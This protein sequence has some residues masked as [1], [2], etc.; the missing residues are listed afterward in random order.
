MR[1]SL[2]SS[3]L[4]RYLR[5]QLDHFFPDGRSTARLEQVVPRALERVE[6]C[7]AR[8]R[9]PAY[10]T[11]GAA[12]FNH[13]HCDQYASFLYLASNVAWSECGDVELASKLF[14]LNKALNGIVCMYDTIL[15]EA[16]ILIHTV[17]IVLGKATYGNYF[18]VC[19]NALVGSDRGLAPVLADGV[20]IFGGSSVIGD[21]RIGDHV[22]L[23]AGSTLLH[24]AVPPRSIVAGRSPELIIKPARR[25]LVQH[26]FRLDEPG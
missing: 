6:H 21:C 11:E 25:D 7:F 5:L 4:E 12:S 23:S 10:S 15:P 17:G 3:D 22:T 1:T 2:S 8:I 13:L 16:F 14:A 20:V 19:Q 24:E 18:V 26:Y 9:L